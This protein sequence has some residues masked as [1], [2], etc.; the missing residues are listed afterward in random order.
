MG[1]LNEKRCKKSGAKSG[2]SLAPYPLLKKVEQKVV[3]V[4]L[5][6]F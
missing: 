6:L 3:Q 4:W 2:A 1:V 5:H